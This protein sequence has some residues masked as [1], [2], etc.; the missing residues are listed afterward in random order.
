MKNNQEFYYPKEFFKL[1][2]S[3]DEERAKVIKEIE[4]KNPDIDLYKLII[5]EG[6]IKVKPEFRTVILTNTKLFKIHHKKFFE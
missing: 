2:E 3:T 4:N 5:P 1:A 6:V